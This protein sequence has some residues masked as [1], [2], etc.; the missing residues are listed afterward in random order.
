MRT[1][2]LSLEGG[3]LFGYVVDADLPNIGN[4]LEQHTD[5][6][7][8]ISESLKSHGERVALLRNMS[9]D[10]DARGQGIGTQLVSDF[11]AE[12]DRLGATAYLLV[13]DLGETQAP[14]FDLKA[15]YESFGFVAVDEVC[16]GVLMAMP[17]RVAER[18]AGLAA[19][20]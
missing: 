18:L 10:E 2:D 16:D 15:W 9:V 1:I 4:Y 3:S 11:L 6:A 19:H 13:C 5:D 14:G 17:D 7:A 8:L 12:A 20:G